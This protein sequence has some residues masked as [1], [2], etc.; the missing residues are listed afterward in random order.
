MAS[1]NLIWRYCLQIF[2]FLLLVGNGIERLPTLLKCN[3][4]MFFFMQN[5]LQTKDKQRSNDKLISLSIMAHRNAPPETA[6]ILKINNL[7]YFPLLC[8]YLWR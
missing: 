2:T 8:C 5:Y 4:T 6:A 7:V 1:S 3:G